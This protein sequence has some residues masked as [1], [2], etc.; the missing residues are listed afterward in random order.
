MAR[1]LTTLACEAWQAAL[2][3]WLVAQLAPAEEAA[4]P[5]H[6]E[7]ARSADGGGSLLRWPQVGARRRRGSG[8]S[9]EAPAPD[10]GDRIAQRGDGRRAAKP[11]G[12]GSPCRRGR[13][14]RGGV[15]VPGIRARARL[16]VGPVSFATAAG[17]D[18]HPRWSRPPGAVDRGF[19][20]RGLDPDTTYSM[21]LTPPGGATRSG[22]LGGPSAPTGTARSSA[23]PCAL[24]AEEGPRS[25]PPIQRRVTLD[26]ES[27][28]RRYGRTVIR[29]VL[30][31]VAQLIAN[32][33][34]C[35]SRTTSSTTWSST[36]A[37]S[38]RRW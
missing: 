35:W 13:G 37:A 17:G 4:L 20:Y 25:G 38:S 31:A 26:T 30:S 27:P 9:S 1:C 33:S 23:T 29:F 28:C 8:T 10:L 14:R 16:E 5:A 19:R 24:P 32:G 15:L 12:W 36:P 18:E 7:R 3:G 21:W 2:A 6:L 11:G 34:R 22:S